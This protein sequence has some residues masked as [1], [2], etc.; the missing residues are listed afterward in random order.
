MNEGF[1]RKFGTIAAAANQPQQG[2][3]E[4]RQHQKPLESD[5][6]LTAPAQLGHRS[7]NPGCGFHGVS[8]A[9]IHQRHTALSWT[10]APCCDEV[11]VNLEC[12]TVVETNSEYAG[13]TFPAL[14]LPEDK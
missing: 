11:E 13:Q 14:L 10:H 5:Q 9:V 12:V 2:G 1:S 4:S 3:N 6:T 7:C 8:A